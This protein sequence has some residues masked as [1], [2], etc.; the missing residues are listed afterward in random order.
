MKRIGKKLAGWNL[1]WKILNENEK[2]IKK[3]QNESAQNLMKTRKKWEKGTKIK[4]KL[5]IL[6]KFSAKTLIKTIKKIK[7]AKKMKS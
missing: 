5:K 1:C 3:E 7:N 4:P 6:K 2:K